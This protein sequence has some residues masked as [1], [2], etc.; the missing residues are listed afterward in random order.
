MSEYEDELRERL[1]KLAKQEDLDHVM[2]VGVEQLY[3]I[4]I[5]E[6]LNKRNLAARAAFLGAATNTVKNAIN[7]VDTDPNLHAALTVVDDGHG[8]Y[9]VMGATSKVGSRILHHFIEAI[10]GIPPEKLQE[11]EHQMDIIETLVHAGHGDEVMDG[12]LKAILDNPGDPQQD[13]PS[14]SK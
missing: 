10:N 2:K 12:L 7:A 6:A 11:L 9:A 3:E 13:G 14:A 4:G 5:K 1:S 8:A